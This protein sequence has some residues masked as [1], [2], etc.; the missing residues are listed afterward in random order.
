MS[1]RHFAT[2]AYFF[3]LTISFPL[4]LIHHNYCRNP[5]IKDK[6]WCFTSADDWEYC[7]VPDCN[8]NDIVPNNGTDVVPNNG[9]EITDGICVL[10][11]NI[12]GCSENTDPTLIISM[13]DGESSDVCQKKCLAIADCSKTYFHPT[14]KTCVYLKDTCSVSSKTT[15]A[16]F[17]YHCS[18]KTGQLNQSNRA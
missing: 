7:D 8:A 15:D 11:A 6:V 3:S 10:D 2:L 18:K 12:A 16:G 13:E 1:T 9:I 5:D 4:S 17:F 14:D